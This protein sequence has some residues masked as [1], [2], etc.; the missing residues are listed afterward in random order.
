MGPAHVLVVNYR[1]P[2]LVLDCLRSIQPLLDELNGGRVFV[3]DNWSQ[4]GSAE[5]IKRAVS[6]NGWQSW[7]VLVELPVN[8]G[9][10]YGNN[11]LIRRALADE[12][13]LA[14]V[15]LLNPDTV[16]CRGAF[17]YLLRYLDDHSRVGVAGSRILNSNGIQECSA[18][19]FPSPL[20]EL[21]DGANFSLLSRLL[22]SRIVSPPLPYQ[23]Q[24]FDWV[25]GACM[26]VRRAVFED[27]HVF[28]EGYFLYFEEV[29]FCLSARLAGW[30]C[31]FVSAATV[32]HLEGASTGI[33]KGR[34]RRPAYWYTSRRRFFVKAYGILGLLLADALWA[35]GRFTLVL[36]RG[37]ALGGE[38][39]VER[40]PSHFARDLL[41][42]DLKAVL[43]GEWRTIERLRPRVHAR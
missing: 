36:R 28:D 7:V 41:W 18:H 29:D 15:I 16:V 40:E 9:F 4:D 2:E 19:R 12:P 43:K 25:S 10:A 8:G 13:S 30:E 35:L 1:T 32:T 31:A 37:L 21:A 33:A 27:V 34:Q 22:R 39:G 26:A 3:G 24:S 6:V 5:I 42:G 20:G 11:A 38:T 23:R 14:A 17:L